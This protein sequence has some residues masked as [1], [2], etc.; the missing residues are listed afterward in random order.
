L[1][2]F[3]RTAHLQSGTDSPPTRLP[4]SFRTTRGYIWIG[5][6]NGLS[7]YG[8]AHFRTYS[9]VNGLSNNWITDIAEDPHE[10]GAPADQNGHLWMGSR[11]GVLDLY[12]DSVGVWR[13]CTHPLKETSPESDCYVTLIDDRCRIRVALDAQ[14]RNRAYTISPHAARASTLSTGDEHEYLYLRTDVGIERADRRTM[15]PVGQKAELLDPQLNSSGIVEGRFLW[16]TTSPDQSEL[17]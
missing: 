3:F 15:K 1:R 7:V 6:N 9:T 14:R 8:G 12:P 2:R 17:A 5:T 13:Q 11:G 16:Y 10:P 4:R